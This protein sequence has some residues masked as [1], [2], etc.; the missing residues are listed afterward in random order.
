MAV[1]IFLFLLLSSFGHALWNA[2]AKRVEDRDS[3]FTLILGI[4]VLLYFPLALYLQQTSFFPA[5]AWKWV[6]VST[7]FEILYFVTLAKAYQ[8]ASYSSAYPVVRGTAPLFT[9]L[10]AILLA[11]ASLS[12]AGIS[13]ILL[14]VAGI[15]LVNQTRFSFQQWFESVRF[16]GGLRWAFLAGIFSA[17]YNLSDSMAAQEM[18]AILFK[19]AVFVGLFAGKFLLDSRRSGFRSHLALF[20]Q[21]PWAALAAG[22]L[23]F[24]ANA[25]A[26]YAMQTTSVAYV[27]A[28]REMSIVFSA[29]IGMLWLK[30]KIHSVKWISIALILTGVLL[31]KFQS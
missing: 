2:I 30:E 10:L 29:W 25:I 5:S 31:I 18:S 26:V 9:A 12:T 4:S 21:H 28:V 1:S 17:G 16:T 27:A 11:G 7:L 3:F 14:I 15:L 6:A 19:Y 20:R 23:V 24:G 8:T 22:M 13:G